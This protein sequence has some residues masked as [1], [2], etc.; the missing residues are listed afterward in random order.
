M[1]RYLPLKGIVGSFARGLHS[2]TVSGVGKKPHLLS[3]LLSPQRLPT[4]FHHST[5]G[6]HA[7]NDTTEEEPTAGNVSGKLFVQNC[8]PNLEYA[9][10]DVV[11]RLHPFLSPSDSFDQR[12]S[13]R[14]FQCVLS[15]Q[16]NMKKA[17][18]H[19]AALNGVDQAKLL[20]D[21]VFTRAIL[22]QVFIKLYYTAESV[23]Y[24]PLFAYDYVLLPESLQLSMEYDVRVFL[25]SSAYSF[26]LA[27]EHFFRGT[28]HYYNP[29]GVF[30]KILAME[31]FVLWWY[32]NPDLLITDVDAPLRCI[33]NSPYCSE[34][35]TNRVGPSLNGILMKQ[36]ALN[37]RRRD[38]IK[39]SSSDG[40]LSADV[41]IPL[42]YRLEL[43]ERLSF[44][45]NRRYHVRCALLPRVLQA[46]AVCLYQFDGKLQRRCIGLIAQ[47]YQFCRTVVEFDDNKEHTENSWS[48]FFS[49]VLATSVLFD[50]KKVVVSLRK[51]ERATHHQQ[52]TKY[53]ALKRDLFM[54]TISV[55]S[56]SETQRDE[57]E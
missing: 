18:S 39:Q 43:K 41:V 32:A 26:H 4:L 31:L 49:V 16:R 40:V 42:D 36:L 24:H 35:E 33:P 38:T 30:A 14:P 5:A 6:A 29:T 23:N 27:F 19:F 10:L 7:I 52:Y 1:H 48:S 12:K 28:H 55:L 17:A 45:G 20:E 8:F 54:Q 21:C 57:A 15:I 50:Y 51:G 37:L 47:L 9:S 53:V 56:N 46:T 2:G 22:E 34:E 13:K 44:L 25:S 3:S 11:S